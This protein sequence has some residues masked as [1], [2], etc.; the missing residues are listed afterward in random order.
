MRLIGVIVL[1]GL[2]VLAVNL[3]GRA[4]GPG[5]SEATPVR[6]ET[7]TPVRVILPIDPK[8]DT[9]VVELIA[10]LKEHAR[11]ATTPQIREDL[12]AIA[13]EPAPLR[14]I[15]RTVAQQFAS[16]EVAAVAFAMYQVDVSERR[17]VISAV[18][19]E[20]IPQYAGIGIS[21]DHENGHALINDEVAVACGARITHRLGATG[22]RGSGLEDEIRRELWRVGDVAHDLYHAAVSGVPPTQ[23]RPHAVRAAD[24][25]IA[26]ECA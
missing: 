18:T 2:G 11:S 8:E 15:A 16:G 7:T 9:I 3:L 10:A 4:A 1:I 24:Q 6:V 12:A 13:S 23:H 20:I 17:V 21:I 26:S 25:A 5:V 22:W 19:A 14:E